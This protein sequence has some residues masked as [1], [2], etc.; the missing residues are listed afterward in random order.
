MFETETLRIFSSTKLFEAEMS[1]VSDHENNHS[2]GQV[3]LRLT[4]ENSECECHQSSRV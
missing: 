3:L 1:F 4:L 2:T